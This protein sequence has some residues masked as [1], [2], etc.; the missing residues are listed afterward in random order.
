MYHYNFFF[1]PLFLSSVCCRGTGSGWVKEKRRSHAHAY[2]IFSY[3]FFNPI[4][5][6][7][8]VGSIAASR[9]ICYTPVLC[10]LNWIEK[11][12]KRSLVRNVPLFWL[13]GGVYI[14]YKY[15]LL[16][17]NTPLNVLA[18]LLSASHPYSYPC[19]V[20]WRREMAGEG[21]VWFGG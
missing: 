12:A 20:R 19:F 8:S 13:L 18:M 3:S 2:A 1:S 6:G 17:E 7:S 14:I 15:Y 4:D 5:G 21:M 9:R 10:F 16:G 11:C